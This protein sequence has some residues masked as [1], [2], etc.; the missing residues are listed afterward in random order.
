VSDL[1]R[2]KRIV[3]SLPDPVL[4]VAWLDDR[5]KL[6]PPSAAA[7]LLNE[8]CEA[9]DGSDA[10][11]REALLAVAIAFAGS[12][13]APVLELLREEASAQRLLGLER[14]LRRAP[15]PPASERSDDEQRVPDYGM[16]RELTLGERRSLARRPNRRAFERLLNDPHPLVICQLLE[17]PKLTE[18]DVV[19]LIARRP[20]RVEVLQQVARRARW[21]CRRRVRLALLLNPGTPSEIAVPLVSTCNRTELSELSRAGDISLVLRSIALELLERRP[22]LAS[23]DSDDVVLQ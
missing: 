5:L 23:D 13:A 3:L 10:D 9:S 6:W 18:D 16:G 22:P 4:R 12:T 20:A 1:T 11:A 17:N 19:R 2:L 8:L 7:R 15:Q 21:L 14:L